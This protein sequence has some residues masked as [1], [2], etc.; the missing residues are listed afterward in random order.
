LLYNTTIVNIQSRMI[1]ATMTI[2]IVFIVIYPQKI[3]GI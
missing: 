1:I 2:I 3:Y